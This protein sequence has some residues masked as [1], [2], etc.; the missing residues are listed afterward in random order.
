MYQRGAFAVLVKRVAQYEVPVGDATTVW[1]VPSPRTVFP[2]RGCTAAIAHVV[3][4]KLGLG[5]PHFR[6]EQALADQDMALDRGTMSRDVEHAGN[7]SRGSAR[8]GR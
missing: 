2:A 3:T 1:A 8:K 5:T 7:G 4:S 6:L